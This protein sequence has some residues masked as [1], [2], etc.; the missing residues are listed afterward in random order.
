MIS[1]NENEIAALKNKVNAN[2]VTHHD[3]KGIQKWKYIT[4]SKRQNYSRM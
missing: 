3:T 4:T 1:D 2:M